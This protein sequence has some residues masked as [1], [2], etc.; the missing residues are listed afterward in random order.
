[1]G[2]GQRNQRRHIPP[3]LAPH[4]PSPAPIAFLRSA[5]EDDDVASGSDDEVEDEGQVGYRINHKK[6]RQRVRAQGGQGGAACRWHE[7]ADGRLQRQP[8]SAQPC[9]LIV[10][11]WL[12]CNVGV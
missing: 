10:L 7:R 12:H 8:Q 6:Q 2:W 11:L 9:A 3:P 1:M 4:C 5:A